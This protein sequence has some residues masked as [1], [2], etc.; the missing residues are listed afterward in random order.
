MLLSRGSQYTL[1]A[2]IYLAAQGRDRMVLVRD[3]ADRLQI[4]QFYLAKLL[5]PVSRAGWLETARGRGGGM[6]LAADAE[7]LSVYDIVVFTE[8]QHADRE[9]LLGFKECADDSACVLHCQWKPI[10]TELLDDLKKHTLASLAATSSL[11][12]PAWL[13]GE[14]TS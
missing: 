10:K 3:I 12:L 13:Q 2:L 11:G 5:Q 4:P 1:Q 7:G 6:R 8:G 14:I 9:C